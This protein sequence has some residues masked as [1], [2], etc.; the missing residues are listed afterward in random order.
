MRRELTPVVDVVQD[1]FIARARGVSEKFFVGMVANV[2]WITDSF[3]GDLK[4]VVLKFI[5]VAG[6]AERASCVDSQSR[7]HRLS[8]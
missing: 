8:S 7:Q 3:C 4:K 1:E 5:D 2:M 6:I